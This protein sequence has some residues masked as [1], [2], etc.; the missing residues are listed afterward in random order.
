MIRVIRNDD[1]NATKKALKKFL[2][3]KYVETQYIKGTYEVLRY[4]KYEYHEEVDV[5]F[6]G[7]IAARYYG[8]RSNKLNWFDSSIKKRATRH[9]VNGLLRRQ[10][11]RDLNDTLSYFGVNVGRRNIKKIIWE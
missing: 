3:G 8:D 5:K 2:N 4:R 9:S 11:I 1:T 6:K 7:Q 10:I